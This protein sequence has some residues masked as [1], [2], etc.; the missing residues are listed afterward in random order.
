VSGW[1]KWPG[2]LKSL[3]C[4]WNVFKGQCWFGGMSFVF[5]WGSYFWR[6]TKCFR[7]WEKAGQ[8]NEKSVRKNFNRGTPDFVPSL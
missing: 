6:E 7:I 5:Q 8:Q 3:I 1:S 2:A 4:T